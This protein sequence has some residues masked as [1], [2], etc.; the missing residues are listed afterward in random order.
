MEYYYQATER[1]V[2]VLLVEARDVYQVH[3]KVWQK[4]EAAHLN[5]TAISVG[6]QCNETHTS[7][8]LYMLNV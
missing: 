7:F 4:S 8:L 3:D 1:R 6:V 5:V 2:F